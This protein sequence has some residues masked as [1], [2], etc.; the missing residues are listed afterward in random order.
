MS[1]QTTPQRIYLPGRGSRSMRLGQDGLDRPQ[2]GDLWGPDGSS[3]AFEVSRLVTRYAVRIVKRLHETEVY[4]H[5]Q[6]VIREDVLDAYYVRYVWDK[7]RPALGA[8]CLTEYG[9]REDRRRGPRT[10]GIEDG[11]LYP[12]FRDAW[13]VRGYEVVQHGGIDI[14][15]LGDRIRRS[16]KS[17]L[18]GVITSGGTNSRRYGPEAPACRIA[19]EAGEGV[20]PTRRSDLFWFYDGEVDPAR[21]LVYFTYRHEYLEPIEWTVG[22]LERI[23]INWV[24]LRWGAAGRR[25]LPWS[26]GFIPCWTRARFFK[27]VESCSVRDPESAF[28]VKTA[29]GLLREVDYWRAFFRAHKVKVQFSISPAHLMGM[30]QR[31]ALDLEDGIQVGTQR[32][33]ICT[34]GDTH[35]R[36]PQH[37]FFVWGDTR[38]A[39]DPRSYNCDK[40]VLVSGFVYDAAISK[41]K[42][43]AEEIKTQLRARGVTFTVALVDNA[44]GDFHITRNM[45]V[46]FYRAFLEWLIETEDAGLVIKPKKPRQLRGLS[47]IHE[48]LSQAKQTGRCIELSHALGRL[49]SDA[50][51]CADLSV[52]MCISSA[53]IEA[54]IAGYRAVHC[55]LSRLHGHPFYRWG[56]QKVVFDG[57]DQ[58]IDAINRFKRD[59][60]SEPD[61]GDHALVLDQLDPFRDGNAGRRIGEY[62]GW[63]LE[64]FDAGK[65][66]DGAIAYA[67]GRYAEQWGA[68][69]VIR[70]V[71]GRI[72]AERGEDAADAAGF[73]TPTW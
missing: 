66:R 58:L 1:D 63:L 35:G 42:S 49:P 56:F 51:A 3:L 52:G 60:A 61:L 16:V 34:E 62:M 45:T 36:R 11:L 72:G 12:L 2:S 46:R 32:N 22:E 21:V 13:D 30:A 38:N 54:A 26:P 15:V 50:S 9:S 7:I 19:V 43:H 10:I 73:R 40:Y 5:L 67:N 23:G 8:Y 69:K 6:T 68:D 25:V 53:A 31:M 71:D 24:A 48:L 14:R 33:F 41:H 59:R 29:S 20:D 4:R 55:D 65:D 47:G 17:M 28:V 37:V 39:F 64:A 70:L 18:S 27:L 57:V 44:F